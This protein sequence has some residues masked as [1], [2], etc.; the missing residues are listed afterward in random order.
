M[1]T[2]L[3][4]YHMEKCSSG[5]LS[6]HT[7]FVNHIFEEQHP[8]TVHQTVLKRFIQN[9]AI[10]MHFITMINMTGLFAFDKAQ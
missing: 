8:Q 6:L 7:Q 2:H 4:F 1:K 10:V 3:C 5:F 9:Y